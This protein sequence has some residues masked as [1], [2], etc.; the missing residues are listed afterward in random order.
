MGSGSS[1]SKCADLNVVIIGA[2]Y[3]GCHAAANCK[4]N[5]VPFKIVDP[6]EYFHHCVGSL[7]AAVHQEYAPKVAIPLRQA[8]GENFI[9]ANVQSIDTEG[10]K[11][12]LEGGQE[13][14]YTHLI[15]AVG[16]LGPKPARSTQTTID[17]LMAEYKEMSEQISKATKIVVVGGGPVGVEM[18][19]EIRDKYTE[20]SVTVV[21]S[22]EHLISPDFST[23][24]QTSIKK[25][26][27]DANVQVVTGRVK[28][29]SELETNV[30]KEQTVEVV[31][32]EAI[33]ADLVISCVGLPPNGEVTKSFLPGSLDENNRIKVN[34]FLQVEG[35]TNVYAIGDCC[36]TPENKMAAYADVHGG[37]VADSIYKVATGYQAVSYRSPFTGMLVPV[38]AKKG[39]G[40]MNGYNVPAFVVVMLKSGDLF[41]NKFWRGLGLEPPKAT[42]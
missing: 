2:G 34:K 17:G 23:K 41:T 6:K 32:G 1:K 9:Q 24:F 4:K 18:A 33:S 27:D 12:L 38:G 25:L 16:S 31:D 11:V 8:F 13:L 26:L 30:V 3:G 39:V 22:S 35:F 7:R 40:S 14:V 21:S 42:E 15:I 29:L 36:N 5:G 20:P 10:Q 28:N 37:I 19:G